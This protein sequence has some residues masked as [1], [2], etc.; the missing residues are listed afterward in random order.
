MSTVFIVVAENIK[1]QPFIISIPNSKITI[2]Q[3]NLY[4]GESNK[5]YKQPIT[6]L[7]TF[8]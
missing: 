6:L 8:S 5:R 7:I 4:V 2:S 3:V 1:L